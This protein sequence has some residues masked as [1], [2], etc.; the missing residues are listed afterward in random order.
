MMTGETQKCP[1]CNWPVSI[2]DRK[3]PNCGELL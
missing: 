2:L 1:K 3:C